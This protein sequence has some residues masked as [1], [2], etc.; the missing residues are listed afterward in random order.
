MATEWFLMS[1]TGGVICSASKFCMRCRHALCHL[2]RLWE[3]LFSCTHKGLMHQGRHHSWW[4][5]IAKSQHLILSQWAPDWRSVSFTC[6]EDCGSARGSCNR[7]HEPKFSSVCW[8]HMYIAC[9]LQHLFRWSDCFMRVEV[10]MKGHLKTIWVII[11][12]TRSIL[13]SMHAKSCNGSWK[14]PSH[15]GLGRNQTLMHC[16]GEL[17]LR[18]D[19]LEWPRTKIISWCCFL[20]M[21]TLQRCL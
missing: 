20:M 13:C 3:F 5:V 15:G 14:I 1:P 10:R 12:K 4:N 11:D 9:I 2:F 18:S 21:R 16:S 7:I 19:K 6:F 8:R 17:I